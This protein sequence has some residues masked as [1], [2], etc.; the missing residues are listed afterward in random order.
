MTFGFNFG[1]NARNRVVE[2][3][4]DGTSIVSFLEI[5]RNSQV[6]LL[7]LNFF[8]IVDNRTIKLSAKFVLLDAKLGS[9][10]FGFCHSAHGG[11]RY[12]SSFLIAAWAE[13]HLFLSS[14]TDR[15]AIG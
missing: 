10:Y 9:L 5:D 15:T 13:S 4:T 3:I 1:S 12:R 8:S 6:S 2:A 11:E 14:F 7:K